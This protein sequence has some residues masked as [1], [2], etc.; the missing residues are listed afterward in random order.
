MSAF[1][2]DEFGSG[3]DLFDG[4]TAEELVQKPSVKH[5]RDYSIGVEALNPTKKA[6][7]AP[8]NAEDQSRLRLAEKILAENFGYKSFRHEQKAAINRIL[9]GK[10]SLVVFPTGA[11]KSLCYQVSFPM[12]FLSLP[13]SPL[14]TPLQIPAIAFPELDRQT[15]E[16]HLNDSGISI[17]VSPLIALMKDQVD[18]LKKKGIAAE[19][20]DS[21][22]TR[23]ELQEINKSLRE[24][25]LRLL[26]CAP[27][28]LNNEGFVEMM[29]RVKGGVRLIGVDEA[30]CISEVCFPV[31]TIRIIIANRFL[32]GTFFPSRLLERLESCLHVGQLGTDTT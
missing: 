20:I 13:D 27:E 9:A 17:V 15:N 4:V 26:Y 7:F 24:G 23:E 19:C 31:P 14:L 32:V 11:G 18:A 30:H 3:D 29:K 16:R 5:E 25:K 12:P 21:T 22:K 28:R 8:E 2:D 10:N 1:E 6:R